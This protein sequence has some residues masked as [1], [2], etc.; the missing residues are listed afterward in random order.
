MLAL[1]SSFWI[2][3]IA[4]H[5]GLTIILSWLRAIVLFASL[6]TASSLLATEYHADPSATSGPSYYREL[7]SQ[8]QPGDTLHLPAGTYRERLVLSGV[9]GTES[10]WIT[11]TG[12]GQRCPSD[13]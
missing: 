7:L 3:G 6:L 2:R 11:I 12:A 9:N 4:M 8:L 10:S 5:R 1:S 13:Y